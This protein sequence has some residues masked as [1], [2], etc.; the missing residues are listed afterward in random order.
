MLEKRYSLFFILTID[1]CT[2]G[3]RKCISYFLKFNEKQQCNESRHANRRENP[4]CLSPRDRQARHSISTVMY[5][6]L[7]RLYTQIFILKEMGGFSSYGAK[8]SL[9]LRSL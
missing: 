2:N 9:I 6:Y 5:I 1:S 3:M 4:T 7:M 8:P